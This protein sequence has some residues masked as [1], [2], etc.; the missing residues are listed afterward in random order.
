MPKFCVVPLLPSLVPPWHYQTLCL[1]PSVGTVRNLNLLANC[2]KSPDRPIAGQEQIIGSQ[3]PPPTCTRN[4][5][6]NRNFAGSKMS[7]GA[8][9]SGQKW[10]KPEHRVPSS[11]R[12]SSHSAPAKESGVRL[13]LRLGVGRIHSPRQN[14]S[15][16]PNT[17]SC[18][19]MCPRRSV[20]VY[21]LYFLM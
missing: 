15:K 16:S 2:F 14:T 10:A 11:A 1:P 19:Y 6:Q 13:Q 9:I 18:D 3:R 12:S 8:Q 20:R 7:H 17:A 4:P 5:R 21:L